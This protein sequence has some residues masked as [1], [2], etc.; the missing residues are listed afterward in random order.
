M[1]HAGS[2]PVTMSSSRSNLPTRRIDMVTARFVQKYQLNQ[3]TEPI[4]IFPDLL[5]LRP[6]PRERWVDWTLL[7]D[8]S[9]TKAAQ[10]AKKID[11]RLSRSLIHLPVAITGEC[12]IDEYH[13]RVARI[14][15]LRRHHVATQHSRVATRKLREGGGPN[16]KR[17][18]RLGMHHCF[19]GRPLPSLTCLHIERVCDIRGDSCREQCSL[20][21][22]RR[23]VDVPHG[24]ANG[25][26]DLFGNLRH[27]Q[28][29]WPRYLVA[30]ALVPRVVQ[31]RKGGFRDVL[32]VH[33]GKL[34]VL[35][36]KEERT[37]AD[38][39]WPF[40]QVLRHE[41]TGTQ[42]GPGHPGA[43]EILLDFRVHPV[44]EKR[45]SE[46]RVQAG[47]LDDVANTPAFL[48]GERTHE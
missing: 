21:F 23:D 12:E 22:R 33:G 28:S 30:F 35:Q 15:G 18:V 48:A 36:G 7:F 14:K 2:A 43:F 41:L 10:R 17:E 31:Q 27:A 34:C 26:G 13:R 16:A 42:V 8:G 38:D 45:R 39:R 47:E 29:F 1:D 32:H 6:V 20:S 19:T 25:K 3:D 37:F 5:G 44:K 11:G 4:P 46:G 40:P 9:G 24:L